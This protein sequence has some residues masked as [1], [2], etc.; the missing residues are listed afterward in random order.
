MN[1]VILGSYNTVL[2]SW[3]PP[4]S[5]GNCTITQYILQRRRIE[6]DVWEDVSQDEST[7]HVVEDLIPG[8]TYI[9]RVTAIN[10]IGMSPYSKP[11]APVVLV[12]DTALDGD[13]PSMDVRLK[14]TAFDL[15]YELG[16]E[17]GR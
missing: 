6:F 14:N 11:S 10:E 5:D 1:G 15:E 12:A 16:E 2:I 17:I 4:A 3:L 8:L 9:F 7:A 13:S